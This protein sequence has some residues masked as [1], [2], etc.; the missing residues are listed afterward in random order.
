LGQ[1][2]FLLGACGSLEVASALPTGMCESNIVDRALELIDRG[3]RTAAK[4]SAL[5]NWLPH[6]GAGDH[7]PRVTEILSLLDGAGKEKPRLLGITAP[8]LPKSRLDEALKHAATIDQQS[9]PWL[10]PLPVKLAELGSCDK[11]LRFVHA[12]H[13]PAVRAGALAGLMPHIQAD[14]LAENVTLCI[15]WMAESDDQFKCREA[16]SALAPALPKV[17]VDALHAIWRNV[18]FRF[19]GKRREALLADIRGMLPLI[20]ALGGQK[21]V[22]LGFL[23]LWDATTWWSQHLTE[24]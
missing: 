13:D 21:A 3:R 8:Y 9:V 15:A 6:L 22:Q 7:A 20:S 24:G 10:L 23:A 19:A 4:A 1:A 11:A 18:A 12:I 2:D 14:K 5:A 17:P 16:W